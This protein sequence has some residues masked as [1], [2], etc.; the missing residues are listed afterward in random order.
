MK[1]KFDFLREVYCG[2]ESVWSNG[3]FV[4]TVGVN[5]KIISRYVLMQGKEDA[6]QAQLEL[7]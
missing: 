5:D 6:G 4:S 2:T 7:E 1:M 3:Y